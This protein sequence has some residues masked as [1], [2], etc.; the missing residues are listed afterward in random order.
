MSSSI[1]KQ[2]D[3]LTGHILKMNDRF[4][5][6]DKRFDKMDKRF[7]NVEQEMKDGFKEAKE[8]REQGFK[9]AKVAREQGFKE[10]ETGRDEIMQF[11]S[12]TV[13]T[14][15]D[16]VHLEDKIYMSIANK[17]DFLED[18]FNGGKAGIY[19][20]LE[21]IKKILAN[22]EKVLRNADSENRKD[23]E[24]AFSDIKLLDG[25]MTIL[26]QQVQAA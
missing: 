5:S 13:A 16:L 6:M 15:N 10:A 23:V 1:E 17:T 3:I 24:A 22:A 12:E 9:E 18:E 21:D 8:A 7:D 25:R 14:K 11:L 26:E 20:E 2:L 19:K 4:D